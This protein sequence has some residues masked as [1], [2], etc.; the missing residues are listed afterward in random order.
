[1]IMLNAS[2]DDLEA[3]KP[4]VEQQGY[5]IPDTKIS[6][7][8]NRRGKYKDVLLWCTS[9]KATCKIEPKFVTDYTYSVIDIP[10]LEIQVTPREDGAFEV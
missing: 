1:M 4:L 2:Q 10:A 9:N 3:L 5:P 6:V 8:K 7:Y